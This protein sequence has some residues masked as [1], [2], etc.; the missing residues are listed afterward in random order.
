MADTYPINAVT[1]AVA[2][3]DTFTPATV[4]IDDIFT[5]TVT[6][7]DGITNA[8]NCVGIMGAGVAAEFR[9]QLPLEYYLCYREACER[10]ALMLGNIHVWDFRPAHR[11]AVVNFP[12]MQVPGGTVNPAAIRMSMR[13]LRDYMIELAAEEKYVVS[14]G[15]PALGCGIGDFNFHDLIPIVVGELDAAPVHVTLYMPR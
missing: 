3:V 6:G 2:Q 14:L 4:E 12:T 1:T 15:I 5:L 9:R 10:G 8:V 11:Y 7:D 13:R